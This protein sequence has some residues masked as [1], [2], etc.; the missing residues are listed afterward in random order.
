VTS[1]AA[2]PSEAVEVGLPVDE[3]DLVLLRA[4]A[5]SP[6]VAEAARTVGLPPKV[7]SR[8]LDR[9]EHRLH[10][11][12]LHRHDDRVAVSPAG[13]RVLAAGASLLAA[14]AAAAQ[15]T[16]DVAAGVR[17]GLPGLRL[18]GFGTNWD[19]FADDLAAGLPGVLLELT[20]AE[21]AEAAE[22]YDRRLV[23]LVYA[24]QVGEPL[25]LARPAHSLAVLDEP[26]WVA[27]PAT[28]PSA[29]DAAVPLGHLVAD[30]W[31]TGTT[32]LAGRLVRAAG[33]GAGFVPRV[34]EP[35]CSAPA[36]RSMVAQGLGVTLVSPLATLPGPGARIVH[37]PLTDPPLRHHVL[38]FD[39]DLVDDR[40]AR[41]VVHRL[42]RQYATA[43]AR[44]NP[45][46]RTGPGFPVP[47]PD[48]DDP[49]AS[50]TADPALLAGLRVTGRPIPAGRLTLDDVHLLH[51]IAATGSLN[52]AARV[53]LVSQPALS[54]R[55][56]RLE[57]TLGTALLVRSNTGSSLSPLAG[58]L[59]G[60]ISGAV[61]AF[62]AALA[63]HPRHGH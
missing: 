5:S 2:R 19:T 30:R 44:R 34:G 41:L 60:Q 25:P 33:A 3:T 51:A 43:A 59:L 37:R 12:L 38:L 17:P 7:A 47:R 52:R 11:V 16:I 56:R 29:A 61:A 22:L 62:R 46:Y 50:L 57:E 48:A 45:A 10:L 20:V 40:V 49:A 8:R 21:P 14:I 15:T 42:R 63:P 1:E 35:V 53:L 31:L 36:A 27:L 13:R 39:P 6:S 24:W 4:A 32:D 28:H 58:A 26:L 18:A 55:V 23:D 9:L 54:R